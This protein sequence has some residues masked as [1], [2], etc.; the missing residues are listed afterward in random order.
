MVPSRLQYAEQGKKRK[1]KDFLLR[2]VCVCD[3]LQCSQSELDLC[4]F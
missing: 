2:V 1:K 4:Q 3:D